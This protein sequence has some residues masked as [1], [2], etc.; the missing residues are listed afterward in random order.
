MQPEARKS[1]YD[2]VRAG[3]SILRFTE[4]KDLAVYSTDD[5]LRSAV[6]RQFEIL[7]EALGRV[8]RLEPA[9]ARQ[10]PDRERIIAFRNVLAHGYDAVDDTVVWD[11]VRHWL[12]QLLMQA[13]QLLNQTD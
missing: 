1:L 6:E 11:I 3:E 2:L 7:G 8:T 13:R 9:I 4:G 10:V 12:P 5:L